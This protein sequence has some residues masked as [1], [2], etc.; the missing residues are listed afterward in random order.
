M[1]HDDN[2]GNKG[3]GMTLSAIIEAIG[4]EPY[5]REDA[6]VIYCADCMDILPKIP[7]RRMG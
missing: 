6:G 4:V 3:A 7:I 1:C 2:A 5:H